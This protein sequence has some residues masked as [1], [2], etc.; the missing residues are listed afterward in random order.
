MTM[1]LIK[2]LR[3]LGDIS[4]QT[5]VILL[6]MNIPLQSVNIDDKKLLESGLGTL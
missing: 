2:I 5:F 4:Y 3:M 1:T 6:A